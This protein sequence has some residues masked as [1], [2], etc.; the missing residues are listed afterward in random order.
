MPLRVFGRTFLMVAMLPFLFFK[1]KN[2]DV[3]T[4]QTAAVD[5]STQ[6]MIDILEGIRKKHNNPANNFCAEAKI[7]KCD[8]DLAVTTD[9]AARL[10]IQ[11]IKAQ[12]MLEYGDEAGSIAIYEDLFKMVG[13]NPEARGQ[14][15]TLLGM[16]YLRLAERNNCVMGHGS[17]SCI[18]PIQGS[19]IHKNKDAARKAAGFFEL[20]MAEKPDDLDAR[21]LLNIAY[22]V[23]GEYPSGVPAKWLIGGLDAPDAHPVKQFADLST[24]LGMMVDNRSGGSILEDFDGDGDLDYV[25]S[26]WG[27]DDPMHFFENNGAG[28]FTD[29]S[30]KTGLGRIMGGLNLTQTDYNN[31]GLIDIFVLR[32]AW[33]GQVGYGEQP[34]SLLKNNGD[35]TFSDV[36]ID[37]GLLSYCPTQ[38]ATWNDFNNDGWLDVFIGNETTDAQHLYPCEL[39]MNNKNGTFTNIAG[40][41]KE[42]NITVFAKGVASGDFDNDGWI[43]LFISTLT[44]QKV[45]LRNKGLAGAEPKFDY[46]SQSAGLATETGRTFPTWF[47]DY[48]ND[49]WLDIFSCNYEFNRPLSFYAAREALNPS[50]DWAGKPYIFKNNKNGTFA[51][52]SQKL[53]LNKTAFAM[54]ANFGDFDNDG[55]LDF[56]LSTG[57]P[58]YMSLVP[59]RLFHNIGG[60]KFEDVTNSSRT[61]NLQKGHAVSFGDLDNDGDQD[62]HADLG[63][64]FRGDHFPNALYVNPGQNDNHFIYLK[65][66]GKTS[67][68]L[69]IGANLTIKFTENGK[70]RM[71]YREVNSGG[72][73]GCSPLRREIGIGQATQIDEI[74]VK[75]PA[76]K[77]VQTFKNVQADQLIKITEGKDEF[78][79]LPLP[80]MVFKRADGTVPMCPPVN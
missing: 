30:K 16:A 17:E 59:N 12:A 13:T 56:Y 60:Q 65:L 58:N 49:G 9:P 76:S 24:D 48:D 8:A 4:G 80:K 45:L 36:T 69:A 44:G 47:F 3:K 79:K 27:L 5:A 51:N 20:K 21:W 22:M 31:D 25:T 38:T 72:S 73:F 1:C 74:I 15:L 39:Y 33:Q 57:N 14:L 55:W 70:Q 28:S 35:G 52:V 61:G 46:V 64:A 11:F 67:N 42:L 62:I 37:A 18:M 53:G 63:G 78:E 66:E 23:L 43:D 40:A 68:R 10:N 29:I 6:K 7:A 34:N 77:T 75:W 71:V 50:S 32:G 2:D 41:G 26:A 54:G 19:G